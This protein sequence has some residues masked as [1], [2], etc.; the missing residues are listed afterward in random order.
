MTL[1]GKKYTSK[2]KEDFMKNYDENS[3]KEYI[4]GVDI[5][6]SKNFYHLHNELLFLSE[7][8]KINNYNKLVC[9]LY[10]K[11]NYVVHIRT[12][13]QA[14][15]HGLLFK[16]VHKLILFNQKAWLNHILI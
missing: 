11:N 10:D 16:K 15:N 1:N 2:F 13:K 8:V 7:R 6:Y 14:L 5:E 4:L 3:N 12:L 9:N